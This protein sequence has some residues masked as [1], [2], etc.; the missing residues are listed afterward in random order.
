MKGRK[1]R[2]NRNLKA[3]SQQSWRELE[4]CGTSRIQTT[5]SNRRRLYN[6]SKRLLFGLLGMSFA[7][8]IYFLGKQ[9]FSQPGL[10]AQ[11][12]SSPIE[13][14]RY[15]TNGQLSNR[16]LQS[17][18]ALAPNTG[19]LEVDIFALK[20]KLEAHPQI[21]RAEI[22]RNFPNELRVQL[23]EHNPIL[24]L[25]LMDKSGRKQLKLVSETGHVFTPIG[26]HPSKLKKFPFVRPFRNN[27]GTYF[28]IRGINRIS[29]VLKKFEEKVPGL[30]AQ[31]KVVSLEHF[32][33]IR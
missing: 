8:G 1:T 13:K 20:N 27:Q 30:S 5:K 15:T 23:F 29:E 31:I 17:F 19:M 22:Q 2:S 6:W 16:W 4:A 12:P 7:T 33:G 3:I 25:A 10:E 11:A 28:P 21:L 14:I 9:Q 24:R 26:Y 18:L 32:S